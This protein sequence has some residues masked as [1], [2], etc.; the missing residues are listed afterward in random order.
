MYLAYFVKKV[1]KLTLELILRRVE[2]KKVP[3]IFCD[4]VL[5]GVVVNTIHFSPDRTGNYKLILSDGVE[6]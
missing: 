2:I 4:S 1:L 5:G 3:V 6:R